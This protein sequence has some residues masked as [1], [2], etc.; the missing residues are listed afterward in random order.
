MYA[1]LVSFV[2]LPDTRAELCRVIEE[3][4]A[5]LLEQQAG[6]A[7]HITLLAEREP[8]VVTAISF[9]R[10]TRDAE[11]YRDNTFPQVVKL[12]ESLLATKPMVSEFHCLTNMRKMPAGKV[13][14]F[15]PTSKT[16]E[17]HTWP[18]QD[19]KVR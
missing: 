10:T 18:E 16:G 12:L 6:F 1:R 2:T 11:I 5:P 9:W 19:A 17:I 8:R 7:G 15:S 13:I 14:R 4:V 3:E